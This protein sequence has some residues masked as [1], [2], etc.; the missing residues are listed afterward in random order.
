V[1]PLY[2]RCVACAKEGIDRF[3]QYGFTCWPDIA[4]HPVTVAGYVWSCVDHRETVEARWRKE[5][6]LDSP[7]ISSGKP[8][9]S[10]GGEIPSRAPDT[11][12]GALDL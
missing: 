5:H 4:A 12:Q 1:A 7:R 9:Q 11:K 2:H 10:A 3:G 8:Q 6:G